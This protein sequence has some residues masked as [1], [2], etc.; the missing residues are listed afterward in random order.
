M[1]HFNLSH[2]ISWDRC[3]IAKLQKKCFVLENWKNKI[4]FSN[5]CEMKWNGKCL[6]E[7]EHRAIGGRWSR[8]GQR[9]GVFA[10]SELR[11]RAPTCLRHGLLAFI[12]MAEFFKYCW[13]QLSHRVARSLQL[14]DLAPNCDTIAHA[15]HELGIISFMFRMRFWNSHIF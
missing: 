3:N 12:W 5:L 8:Q 11:A 1:L 6:L 4:L 13:R 9:R 10:D 2:E 7:R 15:V 14:V